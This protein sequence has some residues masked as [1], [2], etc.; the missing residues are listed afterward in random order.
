MSSRTSIA[1]LSEHHPRRLDLV[2]ALPAD[3]LHL[4]IMSEGTADDEEDMGIYQDDT[5]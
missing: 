3:I 5:D 4:S 1:R 2:S